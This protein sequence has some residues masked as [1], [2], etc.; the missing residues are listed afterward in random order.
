MYLLVHTCK[1]K[2]KGCQGTNTEKMSKASESKE[3]PG[4]PQIRSGENS[5]DSSHGTGR[6]EQDRDSNEKKSIMDQGFE[7][8]SSVEGDMGNSE[9]PISQ[10]GDSSENT[11]PGVL[12]DVFRRQDVPKLTE[13]LKKHWKEFGKPEDI[14][15]EYV[16]YQNSV[17]LL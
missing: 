11:H 14:V 1:V 13:F 8:Y 5:P 12:W 17:F 3:S 6:N 9:F 4:D 10:D 7:I 15:N 2:L 16:M